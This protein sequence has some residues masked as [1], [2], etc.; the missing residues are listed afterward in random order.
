MKK[1]EEFRG[2]WN[3]DSNDFTRDEDNKRYYPCEEYKI[4]ALDRDDGIDMFQVDGDDNAE[5]M[6]YHGLSGTSD[7]KA[8]IYYLEDAKNG[9]DNLLEISFLE[10]VDGESKMT[11]L[12]F[13]SDQYQDKPIHEG[14]PEKDIRYFYEKY[15]ACANEP[16]QSLLGSGWRCGVPP[17]VQALAG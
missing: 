9:Q 1:Y 11:H 6:Q 2:V 17:F 13:W 15:R 4:Y 10:E 3:F 16:H 12:W 7:N 14:M 5:L 8:V